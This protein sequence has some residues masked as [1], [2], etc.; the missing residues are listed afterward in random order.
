MK[1]DPSTTNS[2]W[3]IVRLD[4]GTDVPGVILSADDETGECTMKIDGE[5]KTLTF[6]CGIRIVTRP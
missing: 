4:N 5:S 2:R 6:E 1:L 3:K